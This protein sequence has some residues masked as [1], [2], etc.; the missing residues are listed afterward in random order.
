MIITCP[1]CDLK[2]D[3]GAVRVHRSGTIA[4][5]PRCSETFL[6]LPEEQETWWGRWKYAAIL[7][8][9]MVSFSVFLL[10]HDW[11]LDKNYFLGPS[12]WQGD[13]AYR[14][15]KYPFVLVIEKAQDGKLEGYMDW[16]SSS[17]RYR[18]AVRGMYEGNH[19][20]F[21]DYSFTEV[22]AGRGLH[23]EKDVYIKGNE[24]TGTD[25]NGEADLFALRR[26]SA[27]L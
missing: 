2:K 10:A 13:M 9:I 14:G 19:L 7:L 24:M 17:P 22:V 6:V 23:D 15:K 4:T 21:E 11:K 26:E 12:T 20:V 3:L 8:A 18:L 1:K 27:P 25:K 5:C 16:V